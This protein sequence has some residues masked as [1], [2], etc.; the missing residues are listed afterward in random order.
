MTIFVFISSLLGLM[1]REG[2]NEGFSEVRAVG[3]F[4]TGAGLSAV[5]LAQTWRAGSIISCRGRG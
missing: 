4:Y 3:G 5:L 1:A 2:R